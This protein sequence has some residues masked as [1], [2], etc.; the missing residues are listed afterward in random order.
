M[1]QVIS[2]ARSGVIT[3]RKKEGYAGGSAVRGEEGKR[4]K[5]KAGGCVGEER[6]SEE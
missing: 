3:G 1:N 5:V 2:H 6:V 4:I